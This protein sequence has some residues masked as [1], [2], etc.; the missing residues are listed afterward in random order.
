MNELTS[1]GA[2]T[3][4]SRIDRAVLAALHGQDLSGFEIWRWLGAGTDSSNLLSEADLYP[5]LYRLQAHGVIRSTWQEG[6]RT[7]RR[8]RLTAD[9]LYRADE[10]GLP[11]A[12]SGAATRSERSDRAVSPDPEATSWFVPP[13]EPGEE[14][15]GA[16][17]STADRGG[18]ATASPAA[19]H[20]DPEADEIDRYLDDLD[21][22]LDLP[23]RQRSLVRQELAD[24]IADSAAVLR[25]SGVPAEAA[26]AEAIYHLGDAR[27][28]A[29]RMG[30]AEHTPQRRSSA[31]RRSAVTVVLEMLVWL[32][33]AVALIALAPFIADLAIAA[34]GLAGAHLTLLRSGEWVTSQ[35]GVVLCL[36]A[37][38]AGRM[39]LGQLARGSRHR[40]GSVRRTWAVGGGVALLA[41]ALLI[42]GW[43]DGP[44]VATFVA[45]PIAFVAGTFRPWQ[46]EERR[47]SVR[48]AAAAVLV[49]VAITL[50]P[51]VRLF[52]YDPN[53]T[54]GTPLADG[55]PS[56]DLAATKSTDGNTISYGRS[57]ELW[58][59]ATSG[60][61]LVVDPG[62]T[63][64]TKT[65]T[66]SFNINA[67]PP[68]RQ[69]WVVAVVK[70]A[71]GTS[72][73]LDV[74]IQTGATPTVSTPLGWLIS[75]F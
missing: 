63:G 72:T 52:T 54:P 32:V 36:G 70:N 12:G 48:G 31:I 73:A 1:G 38:S 55:K 15:V 13:R 41:I 5:N 30:R 64:P 34:G 35:I 2:A 23:R 11:R 37:F 16:S 46:S 57:V 45:V 14:P 7:R 42:P 26:V 65:V 22:S 19:S 47:Y 74:A 40:D 62:A 58:P 49:A 43:Q 56:I 25:V 60:L 71:D 66:G 67:L 4:E 18:S 17:S 28:L 68:N 6:Q 24:H 27:D 51:G 9:A 44:A 59:A 29:S 21:A 50:L 75:H 69:W 20:H 39:S 33:P 53:A 61:F 10:T 8:Y 3:V